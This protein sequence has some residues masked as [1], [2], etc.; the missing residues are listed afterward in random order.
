[1]QAFCSSDGYM[2]YG[3]G[4]QYKDGACSAYVSLFW[5]VWALGLAFLAAT[6]AA[7]RAKQVHNFRASL[8]AFASVTTALAC[9]LSWQL[10]AAI[11]YI[12]D[13]RDG[14]GVMPCLRRGAAQP[15]RAARSDADPRTSDPSP[16]LLRSPR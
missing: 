14:V 9:Y 3:T 2:V 12:D 4:F 1:M 5:L 10:F 6:A 8:W 16:P 7:Y 13:V 11:G 15:W